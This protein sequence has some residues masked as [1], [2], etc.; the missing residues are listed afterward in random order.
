VSRP[1]NRQSRSVGNLGDILKHAALVELATLLAGE[2]AAVSFV[3]THTFLL[4]APPGD[5]ER[6]NR[7]VADL[8]SRHPS[9]AGYAARERASL[10]RTDHYRCSS[11]L[12]ID[13][14]GDRRVRAVLGEANGVTRAELRDQIASESLPDVVIVDDAAAV[15]RFGSV[16]NGGTLL[17]HVDPFALTP[18][19]WAPLVPALDAISA[20]SANA[21]FVV[22]RYSRTART[23][24][25][26]PPAGT[27][28][29]ITET[30]GGP[31]ELA[32]YASPAIAEAVQS[33]CGALGW[34]IW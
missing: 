17:V 20:R 18:E 21:I 4:H 16:L 11:G 33:V 7:E 6:W 9:Y 8:A 29:P 22:Y 19:I 2:S 30:R 25:P 15:D 12:V 28:G 23:K 3:D 13:A 14:L 10:A 1:T 31:H 34:R 5:L 24:W 27:S 32:A 26:A